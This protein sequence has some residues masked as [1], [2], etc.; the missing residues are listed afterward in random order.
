MA[1]FTRRSLALGLGLSFLSA[2]RALPAVMAGQV[3]DIRGTATAELEEKRRNL[4]TRDALYIGELVATGEQS[5]AALLLGR[6]TSVRMGANA[7]VLIDRYLVGAGGEL[8]LDAGALLL[9]KPPGNPPARIRGAFGL[10][11]VHG[12]QVFVGPS[13]GVIGVFVVH[14]QADVAAGGVSIT[15]RE[16][17]GTDLRIATEPPAAA[18]PWAKPRVDAALASV[19]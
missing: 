11:T 12:S 6:S 10:I 3:Q 2:R 13:N 8:V 4:A 7:R 14:G 17:E 1:L 19:T 9:D 16:G 15:L 5:R 18:H